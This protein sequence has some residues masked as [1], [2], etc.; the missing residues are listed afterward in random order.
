MGFQNIYIDRDTRSLHARQDGHQRQF[1]VGVQ[2][3]RVDVLQL[4][5]EFFRQLHDCRRLIHQGGTIEQRHL[6]R[7][8]AEGLLK[9]ALVDIG[10]L[11]GTLAWAQDIRRQGRIVR[12]PVELDAAPCQH[13]ERGLCGV[14][15]LRG[16]RF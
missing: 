1:Q 3:E 14:E 9:V 6:L 12:K 16:R 4:R 10:K 2:L 11:V 8:G 15:I 13:V 7:G 5:G